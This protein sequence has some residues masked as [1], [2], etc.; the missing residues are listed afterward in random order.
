MDPGWQAV[1]SASSCQ[2][3]PILC[4]LPSHIQ[5]H[6]DWHCIDQQ[7][8]CCPLIVVYHQCSGGWWEMSS[9]LLNNWLFPGVIRANGVSGYRW[10]RC[11]STSPPSLSAAG[12]W[13]W[14]QLLSWTIAASPGDDLPRTIA[15]DGDWGPSWGH[16]RCFML[17]I[18]DTPPNIYTMHVHGGNN[19]VMKEY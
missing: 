16:G 19:P 11:L 3:V 13:W 14:W 9:M 15:R 2:C 12:W 5:T 17:S 4:T 18:T 1:Q 10:Y 6:I 7:L 8:H